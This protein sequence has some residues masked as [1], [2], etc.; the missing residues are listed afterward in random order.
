MNK[1]K[2]NLHD[3]LITQKNLSSIKENKQKVNY[4]ASLLLGKQ[5]SQ[6][7]SIRVG[8]V[9]Q[10][11]VEDIVKATDAIVDKEKYHDIYGITSSQKDNKIKNKNKKDLD[12][13]FSLNDILYYFECKTNLNLDSEKSKATDNKITDIVAY[14]KSKNPGYKNI[15]GGICSIWY[16]EVE[17]CALKSKIYYMKDIFDIVNM[18]IS[19]S[20]YYN[21]WRSFGDKL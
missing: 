12:I 16:Q 21:A 19:E 1:I 8:N 17:R 2:T 10:N 15:I 11:Y 18:D 5:L 3:I 6:S 14:L 4:N 13:L 20:E 7:Q 9:F